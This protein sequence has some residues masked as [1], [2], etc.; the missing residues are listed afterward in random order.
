MTEPR[1]ILAAGGTG[2][3]LWPALSLARALKKI[4]P[5][6]DCLFVGAGRPVEAAIVDPAGFRRVALPAGGWKGLGL[7]ARLKGLRLAWA[8]FWEALGLVRSYRPLVCFGAG[9]YVT[10]PVGLAAWIMGVPLLIHEQNSRAGLS[11][12]VLG[13]LAARVC[14]GFEEAAP[15][16]PAGRVVVTGNPVR[17]EIAALHKM[18]R[19]FGRRPLTVLVTGGSQGARALN[20]AAAPAL[21]GLVREGLAIKIIHQTGTADLA[22]VRRIYLE[23]GAEAEAAEFYQ[24]MAALYRR[25]DLVVGRAG[26]ITLAELAAAGLPAVLV[27]LPTAADDHQAANARFFERAGAALVLP[28][29]AL[30]P[31]SLAEVLRGLLTAPERLAALSRASAS[32]ARLEADIRLAGLCLEL[33]ERPKTRGAA[34]RAVTGSP[35]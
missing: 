10:V 11:N 33:A 8:G 19:D 30:T 24:D 15:A 27:P 22:E 25:A 5:E 31:E 18:E 23:A 29:A 6:A 3:H 13:R 9:G 1:F 16:F 34:A 14:L 26:A 2:G 21:A 32:L 4:R 7:A 20:L 35:E 17:P 12:K 28:Q